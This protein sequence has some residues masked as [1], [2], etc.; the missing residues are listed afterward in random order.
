MKTKIFTIC[1]VLVTVSACSQVKER[2]ISE[3][4]VFKN[5]PGYIE[6][7]TMIDS[8]EKTYQKEINT[9]QIQLSTL[10][11]ELIKTYKI[12]EKENLQ[13]IKQRMKAVDT[14]KLNK[15]NGEY[16][17]LDQK[18]KIYN[19]KLSTEREQKLKPEEKRVSEILEKYIKKNKIKVLNNIDN[20]QNLLFL[21]KSLNITDDIISNLKAKKK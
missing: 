8:L 14:I 21:D 4:I 7:K 13:A 3:S 15:I 12:N 9:K 19:D 6:N 2:Y 17:L 5:I 1:M 18:I 20:S 16:E 11:S 10:S